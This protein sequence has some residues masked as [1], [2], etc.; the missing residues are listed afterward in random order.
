MMRMSSERASRRQCGYI[1]VEMLVSTAI[2]CGVVGVLLQLAASGQHVLRAQGDAADLQQRLRVAVVAMQRDLLLAGSGPSQGAWRGRL[3][4]VFAPVVPARTGARRGD[5]ELS[6]FSDRISIVYVPD[7]PAQTSLVAAMASPGAPLGIDSAAAGC[8]AGG[9][10]GFSPGDR[11]L[12]FDPAGVGGGYD[13][14][15]V[16]AAGPGQLLAAAG[17]ISK[18]Y[19]AGSPVVQVV[20]RTYY[21]DH[22]GYRLMVYDGDASDVPLV[23]HVVDLRVAYYGDPAPDSV[24]RPPAGTSTC[25]YGAGDP[26]IS[27]LANLGGLA[28]KR[29]SPVHLTDGPVCGNAPNRFDGDLLRVTRIAV[30][31]RLETEAA[32][33]RGAGPAFLRPGRSTDGARYVPDQQVTFEV[34][35]RNMG[36][37]R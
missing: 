15:T 34:S 2:M 32:E 12:I 17:T 10:C 35:P 23:D 8:P 18:A 7:V 36:P 29:L 1:L 24:T 30:T 33:L 27:L 4:E 19:P 11:A 13:L 14:F 3:V 22:A 25:V 9:A 5:A 28:P 6:H 31:I 16:E 20:Q 37:V 21:L 26:P